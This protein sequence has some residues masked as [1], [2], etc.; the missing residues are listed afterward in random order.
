VIA[1]M[2]GNREAVGARETVE[3]DTL[4]QPHGSEAAVQPEQAIEQQLS[5]PNG[6]NHKRGRDAI[7]AGG[8]LAKRARPDSPPSRETSTPSLRSP[9]SPLSGKGLQICR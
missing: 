9:R 3:R 2:N 6:G 5:G 1:A 8:P 4:A 7:E